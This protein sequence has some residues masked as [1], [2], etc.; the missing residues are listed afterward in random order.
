MSN[1]IQIKH[2]TNI[3]GHNVLAP[4]ELGYVESTGNLVIGGTNGAAK[5]LNYLPLTG[6]TV[7]G[8]TRIYEITTGNS[9]SLTYATMT[10]NGS[11]RIDVKTNEM[12]SGW[13]RSFSVYDLSNSKSLGQI[14]FFGNKQ[15]FQYLYMGTGYNET[16]LT[17]KPDGLLTANN[18]KTK[19][20]FIGTAYDSSTKVGCY[21]KTD[22]NT[23][24]VPGVAGQLYFVLVE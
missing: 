7:S 14:G 5:D 3:P 16:W 12:S 20:S 19:N 17:V 22:P 21:G 13:A 23:A 10:S 1:T 4:Y 24:G 11:Y 6:G 9:N 8:A 2:G 15:D 18:I